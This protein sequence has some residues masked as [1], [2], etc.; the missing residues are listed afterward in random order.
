MIRK[1]DKNPWVEILKEKNIRVTNIRIKIL[2][3]LEDSVDHL[4]AKKIYNHIR[5][6]HP[7][8]GI[9]SVYR[10]L[11]QL[12][13]HGLIDK[14]EISQKISIFELCEAFHPMGHHHHLICQKCQKIISYNQFMQE[15][16]AYMQ[17]AEKRLKKKYQFRID[18]HVL[19]FFG[20]CSDCE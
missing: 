4:N 3:L 1:S 10:N 14:I 7:D 11:D 6:E 9:A 5:E 16:L 20:T 8:V 15:E 13:Q 18:F 19:R 12:I 17:M 2:K